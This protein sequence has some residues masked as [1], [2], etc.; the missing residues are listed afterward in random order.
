MVC[1]P[2]CIARTPIYF[3]LFFTLAF[4]AINTT[5]A[6]DNNK[7]RSDY[8]AGNSMDSYLLGMTL[9]TWIFFAILLFSI[10]WQYFGY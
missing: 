10:L 8:Q 5:L 7:K 4:L 2:G 6:F 1:N 3:L 9:T